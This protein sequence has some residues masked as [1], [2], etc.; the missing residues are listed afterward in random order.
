MAH[1]PGG[2]R[3]QPR[4]PSSA[5]VLF[6]H[7]CRATCRTTHQAVWRRASRATPVRMRDRPRLARQAPRPFARPSQQ[8][9]LAA[10]HAALPGRIVRSVSSLPH[11]E[12]GVPP[13]FVRLSH[14]HD[15]LLLVD[16]IHHDHDV[17]RPSPVD[18]Q[19]QFLDALVT[20]VDDFATVKQTA[21][22]RPVSCQLT[23]PCRRHRR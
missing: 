8:G 7:R 19:D 6:L 9:V 11:R 12:V 23:G 21:R 2:G 14:R 18:D 4:L 1:G 13:V 10:R 22:T 5:L 17:Q 3:R 15:T 16:F 20:S